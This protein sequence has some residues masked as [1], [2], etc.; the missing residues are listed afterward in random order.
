[1]HLQLEILL[2]PTAQWEEDASILVATGAAALLVQECLHG[3]VT[4]GWSEIMVLWWQWQWLPPLLPLLCHPLPPPLPPPPPY[5]LPPPWLLIVQS[6]THPQLEQNYV[7]QVVMTSTTA[8]L[9]VPPPLPTLPL[10]PPCHPLPLRL[11]PSLKLISPAATGTAALN[12]YSNSCVKL[13]SQWGIKA[14]PPLSVF[15]E[16]SGASCWIK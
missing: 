6:Q 14:R 4:P 15:L 3:K 7:S 16:M 12:G 10:P 1:M 2:H 8:P 5:H 9:A 11:L 13:L